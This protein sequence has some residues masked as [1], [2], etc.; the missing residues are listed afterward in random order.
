[1]A[2]NKNVHTYTVIRTTALKILLTNLQIHLPAAAGLY[3]V[4]NMAACHTEGSG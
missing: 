1:M 4:P 2:V 3:S